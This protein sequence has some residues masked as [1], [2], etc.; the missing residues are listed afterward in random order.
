[1][2]GKRMKQQSKWHNISIKNADFKRLQTIANQLPIR[3][4]IPQTIEWLI[5]VGLQQLKSGVK[6]NDHST[7][8]SKQ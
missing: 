6:S 5:Y 4:S 7:R 1:M 3:A 2:K 8:I